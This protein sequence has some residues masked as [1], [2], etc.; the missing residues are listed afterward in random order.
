MLTGPE[1]AADAQSASYSIH[2]LETIVH[3]DR[4]KA[5]QLRL[6]RPK[7]VKESPAEAEQRL[8]DRLKDREEMMGERET[9]GLPKLLRPPLGQDP[10][11]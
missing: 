8:K 6:R 10:N 7:V 3:R 2:Q 1:P 9:I 4:S 5:P 11:A